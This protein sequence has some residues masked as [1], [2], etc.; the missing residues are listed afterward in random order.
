MLAQF[1]REEFGKNRIQFNEFAWNHYD[2][3]LFNVYFYE[4]GATNAS[5]TAQVSEDII[6]EILRTVPVPTV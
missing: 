2:F 5:Y 1:Q 4:Q 3:K 6:K